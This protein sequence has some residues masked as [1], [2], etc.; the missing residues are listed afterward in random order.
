MNELQRIALLMG[1]DIG[2][3]RGVLRGIHTYA[4]QKPNWVFHD[5]PPEMAVLGPLRQWQPHGIIAHL[6]DRPVA[7][8]VAALRRPALRWLLAPD[9][10]LPGTPVDALRAGRK[11]EVR[12]RA[13]ALAF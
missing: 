8:R 10:T 13:Q 7:Q 3:C 11:T 6:Y 12:R 2:Y 5:A 1:Q 4:I 9:E